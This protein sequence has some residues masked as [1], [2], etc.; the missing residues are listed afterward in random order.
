M[1]SRTCFRNARPGNAVVGVLALI[2][3]LIVLYFLGA[4]LWSIISA[5]VIWIVSIIS[6]IFALLFSPVGLALI[7]LILFIAFFAALSKN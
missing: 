4:F 3:L 5:T 7:G 6:A 2:I 1:K